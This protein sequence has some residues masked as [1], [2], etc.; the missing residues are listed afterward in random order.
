MAVL[1]TAVLALA[2]T[3]AAADATY[4]AIG[5]YTPGSSVVEHSEID[6][7][8]AALE[9]SNSAYNW[10]DVYTMCESHNT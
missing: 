4:A 1:R 10:T 6:L 3:H 7:D 9:L 2:V 5:G 8:M